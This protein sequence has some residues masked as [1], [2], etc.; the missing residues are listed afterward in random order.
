MFPCACLGISLVQ[1]LT[2]SALGAIRMAMLVNLVSTACYVSLLFLDYNCTWV[3]SRSPS[4]CLSNCFTSS[5]SL[6]CGPNSATYL[7]SCFAGC[8]ET[9]TCRAARVS[10]EFQSRPWWSRGCAPAQAARRPPHLP[11]SHLCLQHDQRHGPD[12]SVIILIR[13]VSPDLKSYALGVVFLLL[14]LLGGS[15][16]PTPPGGSACATGRKVIAFLLYTSVWEPLVY[17]TRRQCLRY[18]CKKY[19]KNSEAYPSPTDTF[20]NANESLCKEGPGN[21]TKFIY[22]LEYYEYCEIWS[23]FYS[24]DRVGGPDRTSDTNYIKTFS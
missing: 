8:T 9:V 6:V 1:K 22:S 17:S 10:P 3:R 21:S 14:R 15:A 4:A 5:I 12:P 16:C 20:N 18:N 24:R 13:M 2:L 11:V 23:L 7:S 19:I